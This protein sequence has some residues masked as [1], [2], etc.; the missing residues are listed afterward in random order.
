MAAMK[1]VLLPLILH[2]LNVQ[3]A[4][5]YVQYT[6]SGTTVED[7][8]LL[9]YT[10]FSCVYV[11]SVIGKVCAC[12]RK[13]AQKHENSTTKSAHWIIG[14]KCIQNYDH[15]LQPI[16]ILALILDSSLTLS[17]SGYQGPPV[18]PYCPWQR[19]LSVGARS[20]SLKNPGRAVVG[21]SGSTILVQAPTIVALPMLRRGH[22]EDGES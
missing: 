18:L 14:L 3:C 21:R 15:G 13:V 6:D 11:V 1:W 8:V 5:K 17:V 20:S 19:L 22:P 16:K 4:G 12:Y 9:S 10:C 2:A 7:D